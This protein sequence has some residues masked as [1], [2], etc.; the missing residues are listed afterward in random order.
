MAS[1]L[2]VAL[3]L[4][5]LPPSVAAPTPAS[6]PPA[7]SLQLDAGA[8]DGLGASLVVRTGRFIR[9]SG[10]GL[11]NGLGTG[12]RLGVLII[13]V[14]TAAFRPL[15]GLDAGQVFGGQLAWLPPLL[16]DERLRTALSGVS[17]GFVN[18]HAGFEV[19]S[20]HLALQLRAGVSYIDIDQAGLTL[21][22]GTTS[23]LSFG[24]VTVRGIVPSAR[25]G[26]LVSFG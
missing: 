8:P 4:I 19:G 16:A 9:L 17:V 7:V 10:G 12:F 18:A 1:A 2:L 24:G 25:L 14:P 26:L 22:T 15:L 23:S 3:T 13:A 6:A 20:R 5:G 21:A 11:T